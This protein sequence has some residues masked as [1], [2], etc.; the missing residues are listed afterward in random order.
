MLRFVLLLLSLTASGLVWGQNWRPFRSSLV[1]GYRV[2]GQ[3][4]TRVLT[5]SVSEGRGLA[6]GDTL[7]EYNPMLQPWDSCGPYAY[8]QCS[9]GPFGNRIRLNATG[10]SFYL[11]DSLGGRDSLVLRTGIAAGSSYSTGSYRVEYDGA[12]VANT[13]SG[14]ADS[15][16]TYTVDGR[17][18]VWSKN[19][20][21]VQM[22]SLT[23]S[24]RL[25]SLY[26]DRSY[27]YTQILIDKV[28]GARVPTAAN[29][30]DYSPGDTIGMFYQPVAPMASRLRTRTVIRARRLD[31]V[32]GVLSYPCT[33]WTS[34]QG[35]LY[36]TYE[37]PRED[38]LRFDLKKPLVS[39]FRDSTLPSMG[40]MTLGVQPTDSITE[41]EFT[42]GYHKERNC[43]SFVIDGMTTYTLNRGR[44]ITFYSDGWGTGTQECYSIR[45][46]GIPCGKIITANSRWIEQAHVLKQNPV[47]TQVEVVSPTPL[48]LTLQDLQG[49]TVAEGW[50]TRTLDVRTLPPGLYQLRVQDKQGRSQVLRVAKD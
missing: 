18:I 49:R 7:W 21:L 42:T 41:M 22:P 36:T 6:A 47:S 11:L 8:K 43:Y 35:W 17:N 4:Q 16:R 23:A 19:Y 34:R 48:H 45:G 26:F 30:Y 2:G 14:I 50:E 25:G 38:T 12:G 28:Y 1:H 37:A 32:A 13:P 46:Q 29:F 15:V 20:G 10:L 27:S 44:G 40:Y 33:I 9:F 24:G 31:T 5:M 3:W 39:G